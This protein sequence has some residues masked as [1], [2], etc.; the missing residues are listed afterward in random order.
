MFDSPALLRNDTRVFA[1]TAASA[2]E[3]SWGTFCPP[4][5]DTVNGLHVGSCLGDSYAVSRAQR[6]A[7]PLRP[8]LR[9]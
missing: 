7:R 3:S 4:D 2:E 8:Q 5:S 9:P 1:S 6:C